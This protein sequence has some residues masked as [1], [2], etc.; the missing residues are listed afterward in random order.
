MAQATS[1]ASPGKPVHHQFLDAVEAAV[2]AGSITVTECRSSAHQQQHRPGSS[3]VP[4]TCS[5]APK[6]DSL[7]HGCL[8]QNLESTHTHSADAHLQ[9]LAC[10]QSI[11]YL[12]PGPSTST[13]GSLQYH[14]NRGL[15][16]RHVC[17]SSAVTLSQ[18]AHHGAGHLSCLKEVLQATANIVDA[19]IWQ[20]PERGA[21][22]RQGH[23][24]GTSHSSAHTRRARLGEARKPTSSPLQRP[25]QLHQQGLAH[26]AAIMGDP[27]SLALGTCIALCLHNMQ[28]L[29][30]HCAAVDPCEAITLD[31]V[32]KHMHALLATWPLFSSLSQ[33]DNQPNTEGIP[34]MG[35]QVGGCTQAGRVQLPCSSIMCQYVFACLHRLL[36]ATT[37]LYL[38]RTRSYLS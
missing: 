10:L 7:C 8:K 23:T 6:G 13:S 38:R 9:A 22:S 19:L 35:G 20:H 1:L 17:Q 37:P 28:Q 12:S 26:V 30:A 33:A 29:G 27:S 18:T 16:C 11:Q 24:G 15:P 4:S 32:Y 21:G 5:S 31:V 2:A 14:D 34:N 3:H 25:L 36:A